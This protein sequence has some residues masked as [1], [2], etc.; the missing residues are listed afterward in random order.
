VFDHVNWGTNTIMVILHMN[1]CLIMR[2]GE[3]AQLRSFILHY[4]LRHERDWFRIYWM[5]I[6]RVVG[7]LNPKPW[8][9]AC[10]VSIHQ[11]TLGLG[12]RGGHA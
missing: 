10:M 2:I 7:T 11:A 4:I 3:Q 12:R 9:D 6:D 8:T 1:L 5:D